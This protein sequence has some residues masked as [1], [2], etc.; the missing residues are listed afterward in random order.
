MTKATTTQKRFFPWSGER[1]TKTLLASLERLHWSDCQ[2]SNRFISAKCSH[3]LKLGQST[4][5]LQ[6]TLNV[7]FRN[8]GEGIE[9]VI[10]VTEENHSW[11]TVECKKRCQAL[12]EMLHAPLYARQPASDISITDAFVST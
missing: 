3:M 12:L 10:S 9:V 11:S 8:I 6:M 2:V 4:C 7:S 1:F 5:E